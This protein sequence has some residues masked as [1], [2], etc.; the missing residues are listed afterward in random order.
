MVEQI[1]GRKL[2]TK[3]EVHHINFD[4]K[5]NRP[6]NLYIFNKNKHKAFH[7]LKNKPKLKTNIYE[8]KT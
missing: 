3:E 7:N 1:I 5:D 4:K 8:Y 2:K 6:E